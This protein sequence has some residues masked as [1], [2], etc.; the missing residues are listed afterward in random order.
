LALKHG[1]SPR[2]SRYAGPDVIIA[3][4]TS[5]LTPTDLQRDMVAARRFLV[6]IRST[7]SICCPW[8]NSWAAR[9]TA[10]AAIDA[11]AEFSSSISRQSA[12]R[13]TDRVQDAH[14]A[15]YNIDEEF[16]GGVDGGGGGFAPAHEFDQGSR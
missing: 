10:P 6:A 12:S 2:S 15:R 3:S 5:G 4:S 8:S 7:R 14:L 1:C 11:A 16:G 13:M 9:K